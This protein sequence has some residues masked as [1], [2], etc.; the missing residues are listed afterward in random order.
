[1]L[2][3]L[4][5]LFSLAMFAVSIAIIVLSVR[6]LLVVPEETKKAATQ[7]QRIADIQEQALK[8]S[9]KVQADCRPEQDNEV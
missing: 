5:V 4:I 3:L 8:R 9:V 1:M 2:S 6:F 7:L